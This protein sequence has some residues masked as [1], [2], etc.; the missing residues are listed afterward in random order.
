MMPRMPSDPMNRRSG[1]GPAPEPGRRRVSIG[2]ARRDDAQALDE[3]VDVRRQRR[4]MAAG[5]GGDPA[6]QG[7]N[8]RS[9]AGNVEKRQPVRLERRLERE[10]ENAGL[11]RAA[12]LVAIHFEHAVQAPHVEADRARITVA[13]D[14]LD[15]AHHRR[16]GAERNDRDLRSRRPVEHG[17]DVGF[18]LRERDV[19]RRVGEIASEGAHV[20]GYDLP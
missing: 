3:V 14:G 20:S 6:A 5:A 7:S 19:V 9:S 10:A 2:P 8:I 11:D 12:R 18:R 4:K 13:D 1:L 15:A 16:A 17:G